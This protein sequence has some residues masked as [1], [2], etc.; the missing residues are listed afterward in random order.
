MIEGEIIEKLKLLG[1]KEYEAKVYAAL[2]ILGPSK[3]SEIAKESEVPRPKVYDVLKELHKKGF[4]D[5]SE[6][7]P[8]YFKATDPE[9]VVASLRDMYIKSAE[10]VIIKL[11]SYQKEQRQEWFPIWYLQGEWN[12]KRN[13]EDL[14]ER[15]EEEFISALVDWKLGFKFK[16]AFEIAKRK[17]L[18]TK[19]VL[20]R[21]RRNK[22][23]IETLSQLGDLVFIS[24]E[25]AMDEKDEDYKLLTKALFTSDASYKVEGIFIRDGRESI[26]VY[27]EGDILKGLIVRL[28]FIPTFQRMILL[29]LTDKS[30]Q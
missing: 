28:P 4:V 17:G 24:L 13:V 15:A 14:A 2:V 6:G 26:M 30:Q 18:D 9:K 27:R 22:R 20:P 1:L 25:E 21:P 29:H 5:I 8:T 16:K 3:A 19:I 7:S 11:K 12:I 23:Y 10:D